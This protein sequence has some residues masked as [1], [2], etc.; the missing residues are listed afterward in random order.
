MSE[1]LVKICGVRKSY[2]DAGDVV[3]AVDGVDLSVDKGEFLSIVGSSGS[4]KTTLLMMLGGMAVPSEGTIEVAGKT[5]YAVGKSR[6]A[7]YRASTVGFVFQSDHLIP[8]LTV[9]DNVMV[10]CGDVTRERAEELLVGLGLSDRLRHLP[11]QLSAGERQRTGLARAI[12]GQPPMVLADEP[13]GHLDEENAVGIYERLDGYRRNG[14]TVIAVTHGQIASRF[15][16]RTLRMEKG[17][18]SPA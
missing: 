2:R 11:A 3:N 9:L 12:V 17:K 8:Y 14:G 4:G 5:V 10:A 7:R 16:D 18:V 13:A 15:A 1:P 6:L